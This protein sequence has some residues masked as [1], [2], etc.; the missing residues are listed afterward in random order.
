M[1]FQPHALRQERATFRDGDRY[2][3]FALE[4]GLLTTRLGVGSHDTQEAPINSMRLDEMISFLFGG[5][6]RTI[7]KAG[8]S[9]IKEFQRVE[10]VV[11]PIQR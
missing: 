6:K 1:Q 10:V 11:A 5:L 3:T 9:D 7:A 4:D 2:V 8:Y